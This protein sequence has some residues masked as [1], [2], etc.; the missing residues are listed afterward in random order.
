M[1]KNNTIAERKVKVIFRQILQG[2]QHC[3]ES[4][5]CHRDIKLENILIDGEEQVRLIDFGFSSKCGER[6]R[7][8][9]GTPPYMAPE[10]TAKLPYFGEP[11]DMWALGILLYLM[12]YGKFPFRATS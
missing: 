9:C 12:L 6:L 4:R 7:N 1:R 5:I 8:F 11:A 10:I 3:H 2:I